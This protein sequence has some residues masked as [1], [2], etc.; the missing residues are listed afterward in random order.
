MSIEEKAMKLK[1]FM[2]VNSLSQQDMADLLG[3]NKITFHRAVNIR[4]IDR[5][6][7]AWNKKIEEQ[8]DG[9]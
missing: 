7:T 3:V 8:A 5:L 4:G 9:E 1:I 2:A 6:L